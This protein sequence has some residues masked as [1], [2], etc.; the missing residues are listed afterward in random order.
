VDAPIQRAGQRALD[1][2]VVLT[3]F[4]VLGSNHTEPGGGRLNEAPGR[5]RS[6][7]S[8]EFLEG[9]GADIVAFQ[10]LKKD[11]Y[12]HLQNTVG[13]TF[14]FYPD[15]P[16][17]GKV[18]WQT[19]MWDRTQWDLVKAHDIWVPVLGKTRPNPLVK[20]RSKL[21]GEEIWVFNVH[22]SAGS[23]P[24]RV[25][26]RREALDEEI[27][28]IRKRRD[29]GHPFVFIGD[30]NEKRPAF[31]RVTGRTDL[32]AVNG[33]SHDGTCKPPR[34]MRIDWTF[35][36]PEFRT[37]WSSYVR[38]PRVKRMTDHSVLRSKATIP[39]L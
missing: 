35:L 16:D 31:C 33:G 12:V 32:Y 11:Q 10:E 1:R 5:I 20:L 36:S 34:G 26:E 28:K 22:N 21:T 18:V 15:N 13:S 7:W 17:A 3:S 25:R 30:L 39:G 27:R 37:R 29:W 23:S 14:D 2:N 19:V 8:T 6:E 4:N 38:G 9:Y 24:T